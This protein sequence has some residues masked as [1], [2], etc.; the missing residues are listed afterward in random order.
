MLIWTLSVG[1]DSTHQGSSVP[2]EVIAVQAWEMKLLEEE[3]PAGHVVHGCCPRPLGLR[4]HCCRHKAGPVVCIW[5][6]GL[7]VTG[8]LP[9]KIGLYLA[10]RLNKLQ[11]STEQ[12]LGVA[13]LVDLER[14]GE[15]VGGDGWLCNEEQT[16]QD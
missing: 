2:C 8:K 14:K 10:Y 12:N 15:V 3:C 5:S 11:L 6:D 7:I 16:P 13:R 9:N 4:Q 1:K